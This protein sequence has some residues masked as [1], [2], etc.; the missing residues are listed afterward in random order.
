[1]KEKSIERSR[2]NM[3]RGR[4]KQTR[5]TIT[6]KDKLFLQC[7]AKTGRTSASLAQQYFNIKPLRINAM[8]KNNFLKKEPIMINGR[9]ENCY[10]LTDYAKK[11]IRKNIPTVACFY[12]PATIGTTH[13]LK[14]FEELAKLGVKYIEHAMTEYDIINT[15]GKRDGASPPDLY[16]PEFTQLLQDGTVLYA[17]AVAIEIITKRY[18]QRDIQAKIS[19]CSNVLNLNR[20]RVKYVRAS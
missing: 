2:D 20:E 1:V 14:L 16:I 7:L 15:F 5:F 13:D 12:K 18:K 4:K 10:R 9:A 19:Y 17:N 8:V 3:A 11:W 6:S